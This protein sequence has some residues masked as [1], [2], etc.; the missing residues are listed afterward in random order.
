M[1]A[2]SPVSEYVVPVEPVLDTMVDQVV[3]PS[4][5]LSILYPVMAEP[6]LFVGAVQDRL[7]C[8]DDTAVAVNPV[9]GYGVVEEEDGARYGIKLFDRILPRPV[10]K[11]YA[12]AALHILPQAPL[13][14]DV[15]SL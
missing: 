5:D 12:C 3:P 11:S 10:T 1:L 13:L 4:V 6:P 14:P 7:I 8:D 2:A 15:I 9:G